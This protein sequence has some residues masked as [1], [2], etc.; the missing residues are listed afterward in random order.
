MAAS[1]TKLTDLPQVAPLFP[2]GGALLLP[3]GNLP[4]NIFEPRYLNMIDDVMGGDRVIGILQ[5]EGGDRER[6]KLARVGCL[7]RV[8]SFAETSDESPRTL[9]KSKRDGIAVSSLRR[10]RSISSRWR[11]R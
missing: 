7:G 6:P 5:P 3:R 10:C 11:S 2:L 9:A 1:Y 4:L 8:T